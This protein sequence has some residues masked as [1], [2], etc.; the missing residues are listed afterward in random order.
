[1]ASKIIQSKKQITENNDDRSQEYAEYMRVRQGEEVNSTDLVQQS[2]L[3]I[4]NH[5][6]LTKNPECLD[7]VQKA[8]V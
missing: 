6:Y 1:M 4:I 5:L 3:F 2:K 8:K 7:Y